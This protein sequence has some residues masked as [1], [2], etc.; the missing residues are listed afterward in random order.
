M[1]SENSARTDDAVSNSKP[2]FTVPNSPKQMDVT[3]QMFDETYAATS[4]TDE[5]VYHIVK[6]R[7]ERLCDKSPSLSVDSD[8]ESNV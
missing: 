4:P 3:V 8:V 7:L 5:D 6:G 1:D 2:A